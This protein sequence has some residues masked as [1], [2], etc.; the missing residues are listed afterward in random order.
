MKNEIT[1]EALKEAMIE[2]L[3]MEPSEVDRLFEEADKILNMINE[4][5]AFFTI[6]MDEETC[7]G[8]FCISKYQVYDLKEF[9]M[10]IRIF[11]ENN[12]NIKK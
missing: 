4:T 6:Q 7:K 1:D 3:D 9:Y 5:D 10:K 8:E 11:F 12:V 2:R